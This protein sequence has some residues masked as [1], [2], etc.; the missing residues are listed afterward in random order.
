[1]G[2]DDVAVLGEPSACFGCRASIVSVAHHRAQSK[3]S[4]DVDP[5]KSGS[6]QMNRSTT[7]MVKEDG[8]AEFRR[9]RHEVLYD[10]CLTCGCRIRMRM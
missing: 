4:F 1:M 7:V 6:G 9:G 8:G 2:S 3:S 5:G 10:I